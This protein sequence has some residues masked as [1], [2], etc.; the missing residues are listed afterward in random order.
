MWG[1]CA[2]RRPGVCRAADD[3]KAQYFF[4]LESRLNLACSFACAPRRPGAAG[5]PNQAVV[6]LLPR[7]QES[8]HFLSRPFLSKLGHKLERLL[9]ADDKMH[10]VAARRYHQLVVPALRTL[11][12]VL[13]RRN[14][15]TQLS[16]HQLP[17]C[18][19]RRQHISAPAARPLRAYISAPAAHS[20][21]AASSASIHLGNH[22]PARLC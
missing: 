14:P 16:A 12:N 11:V 8:W 5:A 3:P 13:V 2:R 19:R 10:Q 7:L 21:A 6:N 4:T 18:R 17:A 9:D 15:Y 22:L 1:G 20:A